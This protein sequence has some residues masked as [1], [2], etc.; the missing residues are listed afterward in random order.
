MPLEIRL[1]D[2]DTGRDLEPPLIASEKD[3]KTGS[4]GYY[5]SGKVVSPD[6]K[7]TLQC[8]MNL[9]IIGSRPESAELR[10]KKREAVK[11]A[12]TSVMEAAK[13]QQMKQV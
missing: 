5:A 3:F 13:P 6:G 4:S 9:V 7:S 1:R 12:L 8:T 11:Q 10:T 2:L